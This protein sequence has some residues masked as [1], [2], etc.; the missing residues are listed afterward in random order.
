MTIFFILKRIINKTWFALLENSSSIRNNKHLD[1]YKLFIDFYM[2]WLFLFLLLSFLITTRRCR[3]NKRRKVKWC[4]NV[5]KINF[6]PWRGS[7]IEKRFWN[8][9]RVRSFGKST[10][11]NGKSWSKNNKKMR[12]ISLNFVKNAVPS[13]R[14]HSGVLLVFWN[15]LLHN[16]V[17]LHSKIHFF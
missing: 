12:F 7:R 11:E 14:L 1:D 3:N 16:F 5:E 10:K 8:F 4:G 13:L 15:N 9:I 2:F 6:N 17:K